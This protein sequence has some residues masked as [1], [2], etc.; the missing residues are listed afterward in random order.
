MR[1]RAAFEQF[2]RASAK[3]TD[4]AFRE[5]I[6]YI[7]ESASH[8]RELADQIRSL[9]TL[10]PYLEMRYQEQRLD[11]TFDELIEDLIRSGPF[12]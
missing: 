1:G 9:K 7:R 5:H 12:R 11:I 6:A 8:M 2:Y 4:K 3:K 10:K